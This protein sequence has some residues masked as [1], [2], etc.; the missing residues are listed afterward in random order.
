MCNT[1]AA[2][3]VDQGCCFPSCKVLQ[4][5]LQSQPQL[6][7]VQHLRQ[8]LLLCCWTRQAD[9]PA[10][11]IN[12]ARQ[13]NSGTESSMSQQ[14]KWQPQPQL[15]HVQHLCQ[16]LLLRR[17]AARVKPTSLQGNAGEEGAE[18]SKDSNRGRHAASAW[19]RCSVFRLFHQKPQ[20]CENVYAHLLLLLAAESPTAM[21]QSWS[22][23][24]HTP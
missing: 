19:G 16:Q 17:G 11:P 24:D 12:T 6:S 5:C 22:T 2:D 18:S 21:L 23:A 3:D 13:A 8:Q 15:C 7:H 14:K 1:A 4:E 20:V 9:Q 10:G